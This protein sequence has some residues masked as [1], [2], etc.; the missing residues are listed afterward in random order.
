MEKRFL[1]KKK[2]NLDHKVK[3][4]FFLWKMPILSAGSGGKKGTGGKRKEGTIFSYNHQF[5]L[6]VA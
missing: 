6:R 1:A 5:N 3:H 2:F 4:L